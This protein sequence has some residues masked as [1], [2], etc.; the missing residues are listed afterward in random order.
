[1]IATESF[2]RKTATKMTLEEL[3]GFS[4][5]TVSLAI[6]DEP[7]VSAK[8]R[9][10]VRRVIK[11]HDFHPNPATCMLARRRSQVIGLMIPPLT[12]VRQPIDQSGFLGRLFIDRSSGDNPIETEGNGARHIVLSTE[13]VVR[14]S[15]GHALCRA[16]GAHTPAH[17]YC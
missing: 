3:A 1:M 9:S 6:N 8:T 10:R 4:R 11:A 13:L 15:C 12:T 17:H 2:S 5:S 7:N 14:A 16:A